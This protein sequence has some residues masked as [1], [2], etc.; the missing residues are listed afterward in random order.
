MFEQKV[1]MFFNWI[2]VSFLPEGSTFNGEFSKN[3]GSDVDDSNANGIFEISLLLK[4]Y[5]HI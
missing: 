4:E 2:L 1:V 3:A 5:V